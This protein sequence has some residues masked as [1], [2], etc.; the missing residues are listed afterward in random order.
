MKRA[1]GLLELITAVIGQ[2]V[3][4]TL[5][6]SIER[7]PFTTMSNLDSLFKLSCVRFNSGK[8]PGYLKKTHEG[9]TS[10]FG[11]LNTHLVWIQTRDLPDVKQH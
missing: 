11:T 4:Y 3:G 7:K 10:K 6:V 5:A 9:R 1:A 8:K 2:K